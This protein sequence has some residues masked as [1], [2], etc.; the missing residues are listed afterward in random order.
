MNTIAK[1]IL[2]YATY[3]LWK[4]HKIKI[5]GPDMPCDYIL[6]ADKLMAESPEMQQ[7]YDELK[8]ELE[9]NTDIDM[10][11]TIAHAQYVASLSNEQEKYI[12]RIGKS[13]SLY[14]YI[15]KAALNFLKT[16]QPKIY[17][18]Y[19]DAINNGKSTE[20]DDFDVIGEIHNNYFY[21]IALQITELMFEKLKTI[22]IEVLAKKIST[23]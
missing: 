4:S 20:N 19:I 15:K 2:L 1:R 23:K 3:N 10:L 9:E 5:A 22:A 16:W 12:F 7:Y 8:H 21:H 17:R 6:V 11:Q 18:Q 14:N 13:N